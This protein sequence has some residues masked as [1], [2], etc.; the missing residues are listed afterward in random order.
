MKM[1]LMISGH[2]QY[3]IMS[4]LFLTL[5]TDFKKIQSLSKFL[6]KYTSVMYFTRAY[7]RCIIVYFRVHLWHEVNTKEE[8]NG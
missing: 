8:N 2:T 5:T 6:C 1:T 4:D 3:G 7:I